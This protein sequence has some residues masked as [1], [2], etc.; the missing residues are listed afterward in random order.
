MAPSTEFEV[1]EHINKDA[2]TT[3][4]HRHLPVPWSLTKGLETKII[5]TKQGL[6]CRI[7]DRVELEFGNISLT[8]PSQRLAGVPSSDNPTIERFC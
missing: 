4:L 1:F 3:N 6:V 7:H 2:S 8:E 5:H